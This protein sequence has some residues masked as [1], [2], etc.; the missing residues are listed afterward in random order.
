[1]P[2]DIHVSADGRDSGAGTQ[3]RPFATLARA[4]AA[5]RKLSAK[6]RAGTTLWVGGGD[7]A[8]TEPLVLTAKDSGAA[9]APV[10]LRAV[11][12]ERVRLLGGISV[13]DFEPVRDSAVLARLAPEARREVRQ[14]DLKELG[15]GKPSRMRSRGFGRPVTPAH[16]ELFFDGRPMTLAR[17]PNRSAPEPFARIA[18]F[19]EGAGR[20]D[21]HGSQLGRLED[22]FLYEGDRPH[23]WA[24]SDDLWVHG[25]W[26][27]DWAN[28]YE[29]IAAIDAAQRHIRTHPPHGL[30]GI[31]PGQRVYFLNVLEELDEPGEY[32]VDRRRGMLYFWPPGPL[33]EA[34]VMLSL[35]EK[36]LISLRSARHVVI[37]D[38]TLTATRGHGITISRGSDCLVA[39]CTISNTGNYGVWIEGGADHGVQACDIHGNGDGGVS[40]AGG[41][42]RTLEPC[43][44]YV[45]NCHFHHQARWS[46]C[47]VPSVLVS[48]VGAR[49]SNN[50]IHDHPHCPILFTGNGH[51]VEYNDIHHV[52]HETGDVGAIYTGRDWTFRDNVVRFNY[53][54][55]IHGPGM[56]GSIAVYLDDCVS[57]I[58]VFGNIFKG[59]QLAAFIGGGRD[60]TVENN[61]FIDTHPAVQIDG[62]GLSPR[63]V[64]QNMVNQTMRERL[65]AMDHHNP[66]YSTR[67]PELMEIDRWL[68]AGKGVPPEG[69]KVLRNIFVSG[70]WLKIHWEAR[71]ELV[72]VRDNWLEGDPGF[73][74]PADPEKARFALRDDAPV[75]RVIGF[76]HLPTRRIGLCVDAF[77]R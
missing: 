59:T 60:C 30:Y 9:G 50:L 71:A 32:Y 75:L 40:L 62:R 63:E 14:L 8:L 21:G 34:E 52:C 5:L 19:P 18:G 70:E 4:C 65:L 56:L 36:P 48:G 2:R 6:E 37:R 45:H 31:R 15:L 58:T 66:P 57:G 64:W 43:R 24:P 22:G 11:P 12:G 28:S 38:L 7:Y 17:W 33:K 76:Q 51:I 42:R 73:V 47:Y 25:Y 3:A 72:E 67:Y 27:Y 23:G 49:V 26:A 53:L 41:D 35:L 20:D 68:A 74:D 1:V 46:R 16:V 69:N 10:I 29:R 54:H 44:H 77:R 13:S 55:D 39:G 61:L